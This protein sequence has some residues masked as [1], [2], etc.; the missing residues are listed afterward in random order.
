MKKWVRR[1]GVAL[2][3]AA[4]IGLFVVLDQSK[5]YDYGIAELG[6]RPRVSDQKANDG[7]G[8]PIFMR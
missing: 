4:G 2:L 1:I 7:W 8:L 6:G 3:I 5:T